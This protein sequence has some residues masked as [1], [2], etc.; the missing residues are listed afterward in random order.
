MNVEMT[1]LNK[2]FR[3][4]FLVVDDAVGIIGRNILNRMDL[5]LSGKRLEWREVVSKDTLN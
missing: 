1:F 3:S 5:L 2:L 4:Q